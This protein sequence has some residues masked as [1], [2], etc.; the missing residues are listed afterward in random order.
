MSKP[1]DLIFQYETWRG[2]VAALKR[3]RIELISE[4]DN[5]D[6]GSGP[7]GQDDG[8]L[9]LSGLWDAEDPAAYNDVLEEFGCGACKRLFAIKRGPL[10][11]ARKEFGSAKKRL[12]Y[13]GKKLIKL[14]GNK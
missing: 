1:E 7:H 2:K 14:A 9:C 12:S 10:A 3:E 6:I 8:T 5:L 13:A 11:I 4:C